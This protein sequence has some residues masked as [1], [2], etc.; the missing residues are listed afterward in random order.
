MI[1]V[2]GSCEFSLMLS[3]DDSL[4][5]HLAKQMIMG[6]VEETSEFKGAILSEILNTFA[7]HLLSSIPGK[8]DTLEID[9]P[10]VLTKD[11]V[12][13]LN[14]QHVSPLNITSDMGTITI[15]LIY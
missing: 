14:H 15:Y 3:M 1:D 12:K 9:V 5:I 11:N 8:E 4:L 2:V 13:A 10:I 7:G 6:E